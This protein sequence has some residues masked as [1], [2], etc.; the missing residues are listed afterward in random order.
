MIMNSLF[1][2]LV[3]VRLEHRDFSLTVLFPLCL[4]GTNILQPEFTHSSTLPLSPPFQT[5]LNHAKVN[6]PAVLS[7]CSLFHLQPIL[8]SNGRPTLYARSRCYYDFLLPVN[9]S[10][11]APQPLDLVSCSQVYLFVPAS[12]YPSCS[13]DPGCFLM[14]NRI[15]CS[16]ISFPK[17]FSSWPPPSI[18]MAP[19]LIWDHLVHT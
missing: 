11:A 6:F 12:Q 17:Q 10:S 15:L 4:N 9:L 3:P 1:P 5:T 14:S 13:C 18:P 2:F 19:A 16:P 7:T 8:Q